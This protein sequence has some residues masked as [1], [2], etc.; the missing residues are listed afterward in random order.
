[1]SI[2]L[3]LGTSALTRTRERTD[4]GWGEPKE[5]RTLWQEREL[6]VLMGTQ[7]F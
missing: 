7:S 4:G 3:S 5:D 1:M 6:E 2:T